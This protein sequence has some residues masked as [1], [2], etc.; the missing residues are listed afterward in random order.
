MTD[1]KLF[2]RYVFYMLIA[3]WVLYF[4]KAVDLQQAYSMT[5]GVII[6]AFIGTL[7]VRMMKK[8]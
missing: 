5:V 6:G 3:V 2:L 4:F 1:N 8:K 7:I